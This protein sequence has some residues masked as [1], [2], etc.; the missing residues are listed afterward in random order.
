MAYKK[1]K[2]QVAH[3]YG[4][5]RDKSTTLVGRDGR[6][7]KDKIKAFLDSI[8]DLGVKSHVRLIISKAIKNKERLTIRSIQSKLVQSREEKFLINAGYTRDQFFREYGFTFEDFE[9]EDN[10]TKDADGKS[11]F[12]W[13]GVTYDWVFDYSGRILRRV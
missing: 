4:A 11:Y 10:W 2:S 9:D 3:P 8:D 6:Q 1:T 5:R 12:V 13:N 7:Y